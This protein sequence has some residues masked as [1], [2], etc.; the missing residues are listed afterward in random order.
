MRFINIKLEGAF[1][2]RKVK[3]RG[4]IQTKGRVLKCEST[5][6]KIQTMEYIYHDHFLPRKESFKN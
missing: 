6:M 1:F 3:N 5:R 2:T 4:N